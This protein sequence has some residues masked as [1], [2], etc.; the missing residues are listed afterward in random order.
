MISRAAAT[1]SGSLGAATMGSGQPTVS[2]LGL[3][4]HL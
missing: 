1:V 2:H 4:S 3:L